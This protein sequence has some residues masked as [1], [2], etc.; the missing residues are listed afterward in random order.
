MTA[1]PDWMDDEEREAS[2][3][4][5]AQGP[6]DEDTEFYPDPEDTCSRPADL[7]DQTL[8]D[9]DAQCDEEGAAEADRI[10]RT[11]AAGFGPGYAHLPSMGPMPGV[12]SGPAAGFGQG[13]AL[14][15][16][17]AGRVLYLTADDASGGSAG[18]WGAEDDRSFAAVNDDQLMGLISARGRLEARQAWEQLMAVAEFI[19]RRPAPG[20]PPEGPERMPGC[21]SEHAA[22]ELSIQ[23]HVT[24]SAA[25]AL[26]SLAWNLTVKLPRTSAALRDGVIGADK[27]A[28]IASYCSVLTPEEAREAEA[29]VIGDAPRLTY[30]VLQDRIKAAV[31]EVSPEA[32]KRRREEAARTRRVEVRGEDSGNGVHRTQEVADV[33]GD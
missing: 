24:G 28:T 9:L 30:G 33:V 8:A 17:P 2:R 4:R 21:W 31:A 7:D 10:A 16:A 32:A 14:D 20:F 29:M 13:M 25:D 5:A 22:S 12:H 19:R 6:R 23:L 26:L 11:L 3:A 1:Q 18:T 27:A 15:E